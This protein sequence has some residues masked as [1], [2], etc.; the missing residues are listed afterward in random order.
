MLDSVEAAVLLA[1]V[2]SSAELDPSVVEQPTGHHKFFNSRLSAPNVWEVDV[3]HSVVQEAADM[4]NAARLREAHNDIRGARGMAIRSY[5]GGG[6]RFAVVQPKGWTSDVNWFSAD[7]PA[8]MSRFASIFD[9]LGLAS[10]FT[11]VV[12]HTERLRLFSALFVVRSS[13]TAANVHDDWAL[14][15]G[16]SALTVI[17][18]L[19]EFAVDG[20]KGFQLLYEADTD[21]GSG[22]VEQRQYK[23]KCGK[24]I[25]F[26]GGFRH[27][28]EPGRAA[29]EAEPHAFLCFTFG[30][31]DMDKWPAI[32]NKGLRDQSRLLMRPDGTLEETELGLHRPDNSL[33]LIR[34]A[35]AAM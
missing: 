9:R 31:D 12:E 2:Q 14:S 25:V 32:A 20:G 17:T 16:T 24:A 33:H 21:E 27:S 22:A 30:T 23:Y 6:A 26:G 1:E 4:F 3:R 35:M 13:C 11:P 5:E 34:Q 29:V 7:D 8:T 10:L 19:A 15:V 28:T 18:P